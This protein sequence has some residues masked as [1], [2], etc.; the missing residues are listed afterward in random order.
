MCPVT[1]MARKLGVKVGSPNRPLVAFYQR[2]P[3]FTLGSVEVSP[4]SMAEAYA[5]F[6]ARGIHCSPIIIDTI[7]TRDGKE[8]DAPSAK[9]KRVMS[10]SVADGVNKMLVHV[11]TSGTGKR[12]VTS[13]GR[14]QAGKT[15]TI[16]SAEA[17]WFAGYTPEIAAVAMISID[18]RKRP[19][20]KSKA[21][22]REGRFRSRGVNSF[23]VPSTGVRLEGSGSGDAGMKIWK[24]TM[25]SYLKDVPRTPFN[26]PPARITGSQDR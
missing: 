17:V 18:N 8:L 13:D 16:N 5:T 9:C 4:L 15:G 26:K 12:A 2:I 11:M 24:P 6:A 19:F 23:V 3:S 25:D 21:A 10:T 22:K 1:K 20:I 7:E 14:P